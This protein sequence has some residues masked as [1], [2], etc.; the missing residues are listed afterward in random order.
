ML[1]FSVWLEHIS[2]AFHSQ[3]G[4][5]FFIPFY[6]VWVTLLLPGVWLSMLAGAIYGTLFGSCLVFLGAFLGAE[7]VFLLGRTLLKNWATRRLA[8]I[9]KLQA[10]EQAVN[11]EGLKLVLLTRLSPAFP[12]SFLNLAYGLSEVSFKDYT[13]GLIGIL[14][15]T[16]IFCG[17]G[18]LAGDLNN[19][20][21]VLTGNSN[22]TYSLLK[23]VGLLATLL[24]VWIVARS[25]RNF[26]QESESSF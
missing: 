15:G 8:E 3:I 9:P 25:A 6:A 10:I 23:F 4:M 18:A 21:E 26:L 2:P 13:I 14:P 5:L 11:R 24:V 7:I 12:F 20:A 19:F 17:L 22:S 1:D 16:I